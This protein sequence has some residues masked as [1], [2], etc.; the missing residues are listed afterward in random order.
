MGIYARIDFIRLDQ[1]KIFDNEREALESCR[2]MFED[3]NPHEL[4]ALTAHVRGRLE[5][6]PD[7]RLQ[8]RKKQ[9]TRWAVISWLKSDH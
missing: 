2:W 9:P 5:K 8:M 1:P 4:T 6:L 7:G 3:L